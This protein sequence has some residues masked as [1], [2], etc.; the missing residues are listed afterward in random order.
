MQDGFYLK[1]MEE[2]K[3]KIKSWLLSVVNDISWEKYNDLHIDEVDNVFKKKDNWFE[4]GLECYIH[5]VSIVKELKIPYTIELTF[6][7]KSKKTLKDYVIKDIES[8]KKEFDYSPPSL[9]VFRNDWKNLEEI[10][11]KGTAL[12][13]L[14]DNDKVFGSL[15]YYQAFNE[16]DREVRRV[17]YL[18]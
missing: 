11:K 14:I 13:G 12:E 9:Y 10:K 6:S 1:I 3:L 2:R 7:L 18:I 15:Y 16:R 5:A 4:G 17:L 8:L